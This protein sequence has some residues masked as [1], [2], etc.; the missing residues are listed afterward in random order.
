MLFFQAVLLIGYGY[1]YLIGSKLAPRNQLVIHACLLVL[2]IFFLPVVVPAQWTDPGTYHPILWL[3]AVLTMVVGAPFLAVSTSAPLLQHW[4]SMA[5]HKQSHDPYFLYSASNLGSFLCLL[6]YPLILEPAISLSLQSVIWSWGYFLWASLVGCCG[7]FL[8]RYSRKRHAEE[9]SLNPQASGGNKG[10]REGKS[11]ADNIKARG[12]L[13]WVLLSL[14]PSSMLYGITT[15]LTTDIAAVPL[16]WVIPLALYLFSFVLAFSQ[17]LRLPYQN[18]IVPLPAI[19][20]GALTI[21]FGSSGNWAVLFFLLALFFVVALILHRW[22]AES[23][24]GSDDLTRFYFWISLGGVLGGVINAVLVPTLFSG[25]YE[26]FIVLIL[27]AFVMS[28]SNPFLLSERQQSLQ[29]RLN[30]FAIITVCVLSIMT[31]RSVLYSSGLQS[32]LVSLPLMLVTT[33]AFKRSKTA[34]VTALIGVVAITILNRSSLKLLTQ[35]RNFFGVMRITEDKSSGFHTLFHGTTIHGI[36]RFGKEKSREPLAYY[37]RK[38]PIGDVFTMLEAQDTLHKVVLVG[39]G[40]GALAAYGKPGQEWVV[41][42]IDPMIVSFAN[43]PEYFSYLSDMPVKPKF[44]IGDGRHS[45]I[46]ESAL[47]ADLL[48]LDAF[49]SDSVPVHLLTQEAIKLYMSRL[50][51]NGLLAFHVSNRF[52]N[53][54]PVLAAIAE[55]EELA[56]LAR[57]DWVTAERK[58]LGAW[59]SKWVVLANRQEDLG[60]L[61]SFTGWRNLRKR[62]GFL[63][64]TDDSASIIPILRGWGE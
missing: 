4:F 3:T 51:Q 29:K 34:I 59:S 22:L 41:F 60:A 20:I 15:T 27:A 46:S 57:D 2:P 35:E 33:Y 23:R 16:F 9:L 26:Y 7:F 61:R 24:P 36:Q 25:A 13:Q 18:L 44:V 37:S 14:I 56:S 6:S 38:G 53:L 43:N 50:S 47:K 48:V 40:S 58:S 45:L 30:L 55:K 42:E 21:R 64:W 19:V 5:G 12:P 17:R 31:I 1:A 62:K 39:L 54:E 52:M 63:P 11:L 49:S 8:W 10:F 28:G 32:M